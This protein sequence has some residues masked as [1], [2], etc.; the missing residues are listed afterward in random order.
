MKKIEICGDVF[1]MEDENLHGEDFP[2]IEFKSG[3][4]WW[5]QNG[6]LHRDNGPAIIGGKE[7]IEYWINGEPA[8]EEEIK[9]IKRNKWI[10]KTY[11]NK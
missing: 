1:Y 4:S 11:E 3:V 9:N 5:M 7:I 8:T 2:A 6:K 10:D